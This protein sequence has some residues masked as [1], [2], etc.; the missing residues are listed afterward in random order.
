MNGWERY[1]VWLSAVLAGSI[2]LVVAAW[3]AVATAEAARA[4][5]KVLLW[6]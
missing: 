3:G 4:L 6:S 1:F 2:V 5:F